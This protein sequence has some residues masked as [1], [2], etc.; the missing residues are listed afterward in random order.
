[1]FNQQPN[2]WKFNP[3]K[4]QCS[5]KTTYFIGQPNA[6][7]TPTISNA[8]QRVNN[9]IVAMNV[10]P[11]REPQPCYDAV[12]ALV[13]P[14]AFT[15]RTFGADQVEKGGVRDQST[16]GCC[17]AFSTASVMG[18]RIALRYQLQAPYISSTYITSLSTDVIP[19][20]EGCSGNN[21]YQV[22][23]W[24]S[25]N[26]PGIP[27]EWCWPFQNVIQNEA[28]NYNIPLGQG[29][30][31]ISPQPL[32]SSDLKGCCYDCCGGTEVIPVFNI[33]P[34]NQ[35]S[36]PDVATVKYYGVNQLVLNQITDFT[37]QADID[38]VI[39]DIQLNI[40]SDGPVTVSIQVYSDFMTYWKNDAPK[41]GIYTRSSDPSNALDGGHAICLTGWGV[42]NGVKYWEIRN[43]WGPTGWNKGYG[44]IAMTTLANKDNRIGIDVPLYDPVYN[45][46]SCGVVS[47]LPAEVPKL[48][49]YIKSGKIK[50]SNAGNLLAKSRALIGGFDK[51]KSNCPN[52]SL[53]QYSQIERPRGDIIIPSRPPSSKKPS[54]GKKNGGGDNGDNGG[55]DNGDNGGGDNGDNGDDKSVMS[56]K[57]YLILGIIGVIVVL[58]LL[59][60]MIKKK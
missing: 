42:D 26:Q 32:N 37:T 60:F 52:Y 53:Q 17:W 22:A 46:Y 49:D 24:L 40:L 43:S 44:K 25:K 35:P 59:F 2:P 33:A 38:R 34:T 9:T 30:T 3:P 1:M 12:D 56:N 10:S 48:D 19:N 15:W 11:H 13:L 20:Q 21:V 29:N 41:G 36:T 54:K 39:K 4:Q 7:L 5:A 50:Q 51:I 55:G 16:C 28:T 31:E 8:I 58:V 57:L 6:P 45:Q 23:L 47:F 18:D 27:Q 14:D